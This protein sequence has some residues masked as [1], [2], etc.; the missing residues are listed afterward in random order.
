MRGVARGVAISLALLLAA[1][2]FRVAMRGPSEVDEVVPIPPARPGDLTLLFF[3]DSGSG[4]PQQRRV[5]AAMVEVCER[6]SCD[7]GLV[8]GDL[9]YSDG[10]LRNGDDPWLDRTMGAPYAALGRR[11]GFQLYAVAG[12]HDLRAG[13]DAIRAWAED[14]P[15]WSLP[16]L[17]FGL[18]ALP[19][20]IRVFGI[21]TPPVF[22]VHDGDARA[23]PL[24][25]PYAPV[26]AAEAYLCAPGA[27]AWKVVFGHHPLVSTAHGRSKRLARRLLPVFERCGVDLYLS[28]HAHQQEHI[29]T[30]EVEQL[31]EGAAGDVRPAGGWFDWPPPSS[32]LS[33]E[34]GFGVLRASP[35]ALHVNFFDA[36]GVAIYSWQRER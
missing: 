36:G 12:N 5:A 29:H 21:F 19:D 11:A 23:D 27:A 32:F 1:V 34:P 14:D 35:S 2:A 13:L 3:G 6:L 16:A 22:K 30:P 9:V 25:D 33:E 18:P 15:L 8:L 31:I 24:H 17:S 28:G 7:A 4:A 26:A 10:P 20:W